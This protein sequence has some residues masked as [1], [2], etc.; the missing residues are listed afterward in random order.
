[1]TIFQVDENFHDKKFIE[2][3]NQAGP[4]RV[5][6]FPAK[7][8]GF[9]DESILTHFMALDKP[10][11][12]NDIRIVELHPAYVPDRNPGIIVVC[13][14][15]HHGNPRTA[16]MR[17][18]SAVIQKFK[19]RCAWWFEVSYA[20]SI[21]QLTEMDVTVWHMQAGKLERDD[22]LQFSQPNWEPGLLSILNR[23]SNLS[24]LP[25]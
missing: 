16:T 7:K 5:W 10:L 1:M 19:K 17:G 11:L 18:L 2:A 8:R 24:L 22:C 25:P 15:K 23:N 3:C 4:Q 14:A 20:N 21:V 12:T 6:G 13:Y 9:P